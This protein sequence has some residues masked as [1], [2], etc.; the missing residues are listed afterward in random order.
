MARHQKGKRSRTPIGNEPPMIEKEDF[1]LEAP[2]FEFIPCDGLNWDSFYPVQGKGIDWDS[3][4]RTFNLLWAQAMFA[5][6]AGMSFSTIG[7]DGMQVSCTMDHDHN[8]AIKIVTGEGCK[9]MVLPKEPGKIDPLD[10][11]LIGAITVPNVV[12]EHGRIKF[13]SMI[14]TPQLIELLQRLEKW[15]TGFITVHGHHMAGLSSFQGTCMFF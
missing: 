11:C 14:E 1:S 5:S 3:G 6:Q 10:V 4:N 13:A 8:M 15:T 2:L 12:D 7:C 9:L